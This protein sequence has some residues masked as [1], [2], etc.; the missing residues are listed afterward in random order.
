MDENVTLS[1]DFDS[2]SV[3]IDAR[4]ERKCASDAES[5]TMVIVAFQRINHINFIQFAKPCL[6]ECLLTY[7][8]Y[9]LYLL[10]GCRFFGN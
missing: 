4:F 10:S 6:V 2:F 7:I 9:F 1:I 8:P 5:Q 3:Y